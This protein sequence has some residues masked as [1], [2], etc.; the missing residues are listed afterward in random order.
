MNILLVFD[1]DFSV[2]TNG[3]CHFLNKNSKFLKFSC[4]ENLEINSSVLSTPNSF[5]FV[6]VKTQKE[7]GKFDR[8]FV[9]TDKPY[10]DNYFFHEYNDISIYSFSY[11]SYL[12]DL[13]K[14]NGV[15]Y[16]IIDYFALQINES[17]FRHQDLTGCIYDFLWE[18]K[19]VDEGMRQAKICPTCL[20][21]VSNSLSSQDQ[22]DLLDDLK[23]LMN[24]LSNSSKWNQDILD[25]VIKDIDKIKKR[26]TKKDKEINVMI[27]SPG[28]TFAERNF[29]LE[30]LEIQFR[31]GNHEGH[32]SKRLIVHGWEDLASQTGYAQDIINETILSKV[33][34]VIAVF[35]HKL[36]TP[37]IDIS[38]REERASSGTAEEFFFC[39]DNLN[40]DK[41]LGM[42][43]FYSVAPNISLESK[44]WE[45]IKKDWEQLKDFKKEIQNKVLYKPYIETT[46][47]LQII[48]TDLEKNILEY[49]E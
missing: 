11:W 26:K 6:G 40:A 49:F 38:T 33:D 24:L 44:D 20:N 17:G 7:R 37:T 2:N 23:V 15:L 32:C 1:K 34:F 13:S 12:T 48:I 47:L 36:G 46:E 31:R 25:V 30:K 19:G 35:K 8:I 45:Q 39:L 10:E 21:R 16:F 9:F 4:G 29:L 18:K 41:P 14:N 42:V 43:Y 28:D 3:I 5:E 22:L 27:A